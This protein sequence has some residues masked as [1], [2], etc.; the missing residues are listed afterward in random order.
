MKKFA[1]PRKFNLQ[2]K[3]ESIHLETLYI[4][5]NRIKYLENL[6]K[7]PN[8]TSLYLQRNYIEKLE[9][10]RHLKNLKRL[11]IGYNK[12]K[13]LEGLDDLKCL[14]ELHIE[15][16][17][18]SPGD[19]F[20]FD[21][22]TIYHLA[23]SLK[24]LNVSNNKVTTFKYLAP[25]TNLTWIDV[26]HNDLDSI[27]DICEIIR[28]WP[29]LKTAILTGNPISKQHR[30]RETIIAN[31]YQLECLDGKKITDL[32][33]TFI[34]RFQRE[35]KNKKSKASLN[36]AE[37]IPGVPKNYPHTLQKA[38]SASLITNKLNEL[39]FDQTPTQHIPWKALPKK[40]L[41]KCRFPKI[42]M[43]SGDPTTYKGCIISS[44]P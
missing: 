28:Y 19:C 23:K 26:S 21:P 12:I 18:L 39:T 37:H 13:V 10:L 6:E 27:S 11:Y 15:K 24:V 32:T 36:L 40:S 29:H 42:T 2:K 33:R 44:F 4:Y 25:L 41:P 1:D 43:A 22:R 8:L 17:Q 38:V 31:C 34:K 30:Y 9:N 14:E 35:R 20:C 16:Q 7:I 3:I 5:N